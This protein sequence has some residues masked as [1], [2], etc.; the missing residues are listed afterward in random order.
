MPPFELANNEGKESHTT[1]PNKIKMG[2]AMTVED[3]IAMV[4]ESKLKDDPREKKIDRATEL[5][6]RFLLKKEPEFVKVM[7]FRDRVSHYISLA[8]SVL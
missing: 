1:Q 8:G 6:K 7:I 3:L 4:S 2:S 5:V